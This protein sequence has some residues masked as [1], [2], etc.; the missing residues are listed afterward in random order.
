MK[1][2]FVN[3]KIHKNSEKGTGRLGETVKIFKK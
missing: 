3:A 2:V 1:V